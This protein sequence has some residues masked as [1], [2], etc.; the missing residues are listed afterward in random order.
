MEAC[1]TARFDD[2]HL[3]QRHDGQ[4]VFVHADAQIERWQARDLRATL[5]ITPPEGNIIRSAATL[6]GDASAAAGPGSFAA[7]IA[8]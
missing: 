3:H 5:R 4:R 2:V 6:E 1:S 8:A 7:R